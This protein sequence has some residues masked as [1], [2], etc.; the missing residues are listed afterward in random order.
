MWEG[1]VTVWYQSMGQPL[2]W[3]G[4]VLIMHLCWLHMC[5]SYLWCMCVLHLCFVDHG[6]SDV[7]MWRL[8]V[9][10]STCCHECMTSYV[11]LMLVYF[12]A[13]L[14]RYYYILYMHCLFMLG[15]HI[16]HASGLSMYAFLC[17]FI[18]RTW[19]SHSWLVIHVKWVHMVKFSL[20]WL[21]LLSVRSFMQLGH[22]DDIGMLWC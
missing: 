7:S 11:F 20:V 1:G 5:F 12:H 18:C 13:R 6:C 17:D 3:M 21:S 10:L 4:S 9:L 8:M 14:L 16:G 19:I 15:L 22:H 2:D